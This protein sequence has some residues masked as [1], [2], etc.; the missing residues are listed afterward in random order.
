[1]CEGYVIAIAFTIYAFS[2]SATHTGEWSNYLMEITFLF[3][4]YIPEYY[5]ESVEN[6]ESVLDISERSVTDD[7][8]QHLKGEDGTEEYVAVF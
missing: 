5:N 8:E 4:L 1:M 7:L 6:V 3:C 2:Q